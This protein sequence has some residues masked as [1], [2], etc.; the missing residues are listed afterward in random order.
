MHD[1]ICQVLMYN[2][3][4][5]LLYRAPTKVPCSNVNQQC[6]STVTYQFPVS[7]FHINKVVQRHA[8]CLCIIVEHM[9][10]ELSKD[11]SPNNFNTC[12]FL[13]FEAKLNP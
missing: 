5:K 10:V 9:Q 1:G 12:K 4:S 13:F 7:N 2:T 11:K 6:K 8:K 3:G